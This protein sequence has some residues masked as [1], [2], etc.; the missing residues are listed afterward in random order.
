MHRTGQRRNV[1]CSIPVIG[2]RPLGSSMHRGIRTAAQTPDGIPVI[3]AAESGSATSK[4]ATALSLSH[5]IV[6]ARRAANHP[7]PKRCRLI[8]GGLQ[9]AV[10]ARAGTDLSSSRLSPIVLWVE[11]CRSSWLVGKYIKRPVRGVE[12]VDAVFVLPPSRQK[13]YT[14]GASASHCP[15]GVGALVPAPGGGR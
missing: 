14:L 9:L 8:N 1:D 7:R 6:P 3:A 11:T 5:W 15:N 12:R 2:T 4:A 13:T 10:F